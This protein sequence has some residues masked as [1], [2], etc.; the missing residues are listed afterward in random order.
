MQISW[1]PAFQSNA[2][3]TFD[4]I[5]GTAMLGRSCILYFPPVQ[6][7]CPLPHNTIGN[8]S[9]DYWAAGNPNP[10]FAQQPLCVYCGGN[11][12][13]AVEP[14][15]TITMVIKWP[16][17]TFNQQFPFGERHDEGQ[18]ITRGFVADLM[19]V[20]NCTRMEAFYEIGMRHYNFALDGE[21]SIGG[22][23]VPNRYFYANWKVV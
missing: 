19:S 8:I 7:P 22:R 6:E 10:V 1:P 18:I 5:M 11:G 3:S 21:P 17:A 2:A 14:S 15:S 4:S 12:F 23:L 9:S 20:K 13:V 16:A